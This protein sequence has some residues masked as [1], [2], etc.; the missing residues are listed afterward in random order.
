MAPVCRR[1]YLRLHIVLFNIRIL[2][3]VGLPTLQRQGCYKNNHTTRRYVNSRGPAPQAWILSNFEAKQA[4]HFEI[5]IEY[6]SNFPPRRRGRAIGIYVAAVYVGL[7]VGPFA[8]TFMMSLYL[9]Y[10]KGMA[11]Q[12]AGMVLMAQPMIMAIFSPLAGRL[13]NRIQPRLLAT[14]GHGHHCFGNGRL[15]AASPPDLHQWH[16]RQPRAAGLG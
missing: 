12:N 4:V 7:S 8:V 3:S 13:S 16:H 10:I 6:D 1:A 5:L 11:P 9:Q 15:Y 2:G 14:G